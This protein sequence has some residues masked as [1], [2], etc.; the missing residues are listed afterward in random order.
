MIYVLTKLMKNKPT[1][2]FQK[3]FSKAAFLAQHEELHAAC[4]AAASIHSL[5]VAFPLENIALSDEQK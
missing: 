3:H 5:D 1:K 4:W 2:S